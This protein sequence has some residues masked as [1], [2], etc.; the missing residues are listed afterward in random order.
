MDGFIKTFSIMGSNPVRRSNTE[1]RLVQLEI[2]F[3]HFK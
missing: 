3:P 1:V 2:Q